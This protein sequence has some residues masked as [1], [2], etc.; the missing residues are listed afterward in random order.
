MPY[1]PQ[2]KNI[3]E[4]N[5]EKEQTQKDIYTAAAKLSEKLKLAA[6]MSKSKLKELKEQKLK[7]NPI[8]GEF[9]QRQVFGGVYEAEWYTP[10]GKSE[11]LYSEFPERLQTYLQVKRDNDVVDMKKMIEPDATGTREVLIFSKPGDT[12][13]EGMVIGKAKK[14]YLEDVKGTPLEKIFKGDKNKEIYIM[15]KQA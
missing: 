15:Q 5:K 13:G 4:K 8:K 6:E 14:V 10:Q 1:W 9:R 2:N 7:D 11:L 3:E 12:V